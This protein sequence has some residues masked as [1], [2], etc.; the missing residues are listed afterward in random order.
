MQILTQPKN[1]LTRQYQR[2]FEME[3]V[4]LTFSPEALQAVAKK[5]LERNTGARGLRSILENV[6]L[7]TMYDLPSMSGVGTVDVTEGVITGKEKPALRAE[8][9]PVNPS[10]SDDSAD[11]LVVLEGSSRRA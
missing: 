3:N 11:H 8:R 2:L 10:D 9:Q 1:A 7:D 5:A 6:L 4:D